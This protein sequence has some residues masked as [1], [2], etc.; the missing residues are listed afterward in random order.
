MAEPSEAAPA[1]EQAAAPEP[2]GLEA[3][4]LEA[5]G[6][7]ADTIL[8]AFL[9]WSSEIGLSLYEAQEEA[10]LELCGGRHVI[11]NTPTGSGKSLVAE[12]VHFKALCEG[13]RSF[14]TSPIKALVS[15][16]FFALCERFGAANVGMLTGDASI[17]SKANI[18]CCTAEILAN[19]ALREGEHATV[20]Y[21]VMDEF[22]YFADRDRGMAWQVPL[23]TL[24]QST[25]LLMSATLGD[26]SHFERHLESFTGNEVALVQ[27]AQ[28]PV[29][30]EFIYSERPLHECMSDLVERNRAPVYLVN[31]TQ[32]EAAEQAQNLTSVNLLDKEGRRAIVDATKGFRFDTPYGKDMKRFV[33]AGIGLHHAG[34]LPKYRL[35]VER[36]AQKGLLKVISGTDTLGVGINIPIRTV[37]F[38][39]LCKFDGEKVRI[40]SVRD[41]KQ[42]GG[43]AGR[44]GF[45][46]QG[47]V[48]AQAPEH[49]IEN[50][51]MEAKVGDDPKKRRKLVRKK[52][53]E[54]GYVPFDA[55]TFQ[56][57]VDGDAEPLTSRFEITHG[58]IL[59][60]LDREVAH[61]RRD[62]GYRKIV[63]LVH[64]SFEHKGARSRHLRQSA[65]LFR[66][67]RSRGLVELIQVDWARGPA[68]RVN[69]ELQRDFSLH[70]SL[71]L[72]LVDALFMLDAADDDYALDVV[73]LVEAVLENPR[74]ILDKQVDR[75]R[76]DLVAQ[77]KADGVEYE[78]RMERLEEVTYPKPK[79]DFIYQTFD[80]FRE[81]HP[82]VRHENIRPKSIA[83]EMVE[84][85]TSFREYVAKY[86]LQRS[87]GQVLR[88]LTE[89]Y[90]TL[91]QSVP[92]SY[93]DERVLEVLAFLRTMLER[94][95][96]SLIQEWEQ[97]LMAS[98][99]EVEE[100]LRPRDVAADPKAFAAR[101]RAECQR[102]AKAISVGDFEDAVGGLN[103]V[104]DVETWTADGLE[105]ALAGFVDEHGGL[106]LFDHR[107][108]L[109]DRTLIKQVGPRRWEVRYTLLDPEET[110]IWYLDAEVDLQGRDGVEGTLL[111]LRGVRS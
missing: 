43:R 95:D 30:L 18:I 74:V 97:L 19:L 25:F 38:T 88:Y 24:P 33:S 90:K 46:D 93:K 84:G 41:F 85:F 40:L 68:V 82:W 56:K 5:R 86:G 64:R 80:I 26:V 52:P 53:P 81:S 79:A 48:V 39:K 15:E 22:H 73:T 69:E 70:H 21:V 91:L 13:K 65:V 10:I 104:E 34:L 20:D 59:N 49:V 92:S 72:W 75:A 83:R 37:V 89:A 54:R 29:P 61:G 31:F 57:L 45:D 101:V 87:E 106:P 36:L 8:E 28:R 17:N 35:L 105:E 51:R 58:A 23:L 94:V 63:D 50:K 11:L 55:N 3:R 4:A 6:A 110:G 67:L 102:L 77:L 60:V 109:G 47:Y 9:D 111:G 78:E 98:D 103:P 42:I 76:G 1:Q 16:K 12:A 71:S 62:G 2:T 27:S 96:S 108:R 7:D 32:R 66:A 107:S 100:S 14:Y 44:K 99:D